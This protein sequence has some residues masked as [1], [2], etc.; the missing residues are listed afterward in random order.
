MSRRTSRSSSRPGAR[1]ATR[2]S[3]DSMPT[4]VGV[5][6]GVGDP[7]PAGTAR[8]CGLRGT[9]GRHR[10]DR[11]GRCGVAGPGGRRRVGAHG[12]RSPSGDRHRHRGRGRHQAPGARWARSRHAGDC[13]RPQRWGH[14]DRDLDDR[15][16]R[17]RRACRARRRRQR[18]HRSP[19]VAT[20]ALLATDVAAPLP[21]EDGAILVPSIPGLG[22]RPSAAA[23]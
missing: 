17:W 11:R 8:H 14:T 19:G 20:S 3:F 12:R 21:V 9:N 16:R 6:R 1:S 13:R 22:V 2:S 18:R 4:A 10:P 15:F 5:R 23:R 7:A